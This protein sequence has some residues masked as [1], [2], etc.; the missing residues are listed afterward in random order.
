MLRYSVVNT[1]T[2]DIISQHA[3]LLDAHS[4]AEELN[5]SLVSKPYR[6]LE[7]LPANLNRFVRMLARLEAWLENKLQQRSLA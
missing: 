6:V 2:Q 4:T 7:M 1:R 3:T 5:T